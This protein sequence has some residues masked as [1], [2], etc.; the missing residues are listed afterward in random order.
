M[1]T[2]YDKKQNIGMIALFI[3]SITLTAGL[4][5]KLTKKAND[6]NDKINQVTDNLANLEALAKQDK[7]V[8]LF[9]RGGENIY[10]TEAS[11]SL[12]SSILDEYS[13][14]YI[15]IRIDE[16]DLSEYVLNRSLTF[17]ESNSY[18]QNIFL[19]NGDYCGANPNYDTDTGTG[20]FGAIVC[21]TKENDC[22]NFEI[23]E[24]YI[25]EDDYTFDTTKDAFIKNSDKSEHTQGIACFDKIYGIK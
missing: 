22:I 24:A 18:S 12:P 19:L 11:L 13:M 1:K 16:G 14:I 4:T 17:E 5:A 8:L 2:Q 25:L 20:M 9:D 3:L 21:L 23:Y 15:H 6:N 10:S 7:A